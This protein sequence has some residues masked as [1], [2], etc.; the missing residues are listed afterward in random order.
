MQM[1][2]ARQVC[3]KSWGGQRKQA[4]Y[5]SFLFLRGNYDAAGLK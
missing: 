4:G 5:I 1:G 2:N 3:V